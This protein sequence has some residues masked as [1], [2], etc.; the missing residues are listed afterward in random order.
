MLSEAQLARIE[1]ALHG[2]AGLDALWLFGSEAAGTATPRSDVDLAAL[3]AARPSSSTLLAAR[4]RVAE[5]LRRPVD[6]VDLESASPVLAMQALRHGRLVVD[7]DPRHRVRFLSA[8]PGRYE[9]VMILRRPAE[10]LLR[11][12]LANGRA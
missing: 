1:A 7:R 6:L 12:R 2:L 4:E 3:F 9:D 5:L 8:L 10:K 11:T